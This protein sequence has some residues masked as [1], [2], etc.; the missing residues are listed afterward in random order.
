M[1]HDAYTCKQYSGTHGF[2]TK[3]LEEPNNFVA[4]VIK[5][6]HELKDECPV[7]CR[8]QGHESDWER[9]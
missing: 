2:P 4:S 5:E 3:R 9:C 7:K 6:N 8:R 1:Q